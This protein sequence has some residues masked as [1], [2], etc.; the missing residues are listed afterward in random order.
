MNEVTATYLTFSNGAVE[1]P[2]DVGGGG[3]TCLDKS[4]VFCLRQVPPS[5]PN[6]CAGD[7]TAESEIRPSFPNLSVYVIYI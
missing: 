6:I 4:T 2:A 1:S 5:S 7:A 3:G